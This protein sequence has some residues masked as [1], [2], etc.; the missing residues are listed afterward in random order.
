MSQAETASSTELQ[1]ISRTGNLSGGCSKVK[2]SDF[3]PEHRS[4]LSLTCGYYKV[5][6]CTE[7]PFP[8][9]QEQDLFLQ[10]AWKLACLDYKEKLHADR[11]I[12]NIVSPFMSITINF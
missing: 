12:Y 10:E 6:L 2:V 4:T 11:A 7:D 5:I 8:L 3:E 1:T 9:E